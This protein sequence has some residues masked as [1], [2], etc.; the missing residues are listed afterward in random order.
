MIYY[1][2]GCAIALLIVSIFAFVCHKIDVRRTSESFLER[3]EIADKYL[4]LRI[5]AKEPEYDK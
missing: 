2:L 3:M 4:K 1:F 5:E